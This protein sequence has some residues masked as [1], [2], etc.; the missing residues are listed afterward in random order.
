MAPAR[1][2]AL[3]DPFCPVLDAIGVLQGK[4]TM[5]IVHALMGGPMGFNELSRAVGGCNPSTLA[6]RLET[7]VALD[8]LARRVESSSPPRTLYSLTAAGVALQP[9]VAAIDDW[10]KRHLRRDR[11]Q[12]V[13]RAARAR[14]SRA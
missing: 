14:E 4:W 5:Q 8:I 3:P 12:A 9:V 13:R 11:V 2:S 1:R 10:G 7:L 6:Q